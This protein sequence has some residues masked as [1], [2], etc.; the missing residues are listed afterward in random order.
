M[1]RIRSIR[2]GVSD[3]VLGGVALVLTVGLIVAVVTG[4]MRGLFTS[5][6]DRTL[7]VQFHDTRQLNKS[8]PVRIDG[9][10][11]GTVDKLSLDPGGRTSTVKIKLKHD[12][13]PLYKDASAHI[14]FR[15]VLG[16]AFSVDLTRGTARA[17]A[18]DG[19]TITTRHTSSQVELDDIT[20]VLRGAAEKGFKKLPD[21]LAKALRDPHQPAAALRV[22]AGGAPSLER[23]LEAARGQQPDDLDVLISST[24]QTVRALDAPGDQLGA[25]VSGAAAVVQTTANRTA[26]IRDTIERAPGVMQRTNQTL[27]G[28][29]GTIR[30]ANPLLTQVRKAAGDVAPTVAQ[31]RG[32]VVPAS[33]LLTD[34]RPLLRELRPAVA[35]L[36][37][38]SR[39]GLPLLNGLAPS[40]K[41]LDTSVLPYMAEPDVGTDHSMAEMIGPA[42]AALSAIGGYVDNAGRLVRFPATSGNNALYLPC[43]AYLNNPDKEKI[44]ACEGLKDALSSAFGVKQ[45]TEMPNR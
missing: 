39:Q 3:A 19:Q 31:L 34:A 37:S 14:R 5:A 38:A 26:E 41:R 44:V 8:N 4:A 33:H 29:D 27:A 9:V 45:L 21:E 24:A 16:G 18:L 10:E 6:G 43:Q 23:G 32:T 35:S 40:I 7:T 11:V 15:T 13:G 17:G 36:A 2:E 25:L 22:A 42:T 30:I 1:T 28:L 12:A 20:P